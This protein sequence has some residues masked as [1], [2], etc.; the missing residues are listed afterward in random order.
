MSINSMKVFIR[1]PSCGAVD[2]AYDYHENTSSDR[3][4]YFCFLGAERI[5]F[6]CAES[7]EMKYGVFRCGTCGYQGPFE[8]LFA[9]G[10]CSVEDLDRYKE[11]LNNGLEE[12]MTHGKA[13]FSDWDYSLTEQPALRRLLMMYPDDAE[14]RRIGFL[15]GVIRAGGCDALTRLET[16]A[17]VINRHF[18]HVPAW[19]QKVYLRDGVLV[20]G[21]GAFAGCTGLRDIF[22]PD[23]VT[24]IGEEAFSGSGLKTIHTSG[25]LI[26]IGDRAFSDCSDL[27]RF[28]LPSGIRKIGRQCFMNCAAL[29]E[30]FVPEGADVGQDAFSGCRSL[31]K[32]EIPLSLKEKGAAFF[33]LSDQTQVL[34][35]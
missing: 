32:I 21:P 20:I 12:M 27:E 29:K 26:R 6:F 33:G 9:N 15:Y 16:G 14:L 28:F 5:G 2:F 3:S 13:Y 34:W 31:T 35:R 23:S 30:L 8:D 24:E 4:E 22:L 19:L 1:C 17:P 10:C 11:V 18:I 25:R 7:R